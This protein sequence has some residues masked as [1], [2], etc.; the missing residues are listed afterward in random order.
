MKKLCLIALTLRWKLST[1]YAECFSTGDRFVFF[2][3]RRYSS[4]S[5]SVAWG[6]RCSVWSYRTATLRLFQSPRYHVIWGSIIAESLDRN[7]KGASPN[8]SNQFCGRVIHCQGDH[9]L[10]ETIFAI[11][12]NGKP[13]RSTTQGY[14]DAQNLYCKAR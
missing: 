11:L 1:W 14:A 10:H 9:F 4:F 12:R 13:R 2:L 6:F 8:G 7:G 3:E 5:S